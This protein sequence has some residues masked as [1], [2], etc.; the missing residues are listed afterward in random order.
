MTPLVSQFFARSL[1]FFFVVVLGFV[2]L[3]PRAADA[4]VSPSGEPGIV[5]MGFGRAAEPAASA[6]LQFLI[7]PSE[8]SY[9]GM[10]EVT[11]GEST[12]AGPM[13]SPVMEG[14]PGMP[15]SVT[16]EQLD[17]IVQALVDGGVASDAIT[18][19]VPD[20]NEMFLGPGSPETGEILAE[21]SNPEEQQLADLVDAARQ[22][23]RGANLSVFHVGAAFEASDCATLTQQARE[24]AVA[25]ARAR[26]E[27]LAQAVG[28]ALGDL[29]QA[30][31]TPYYGPES[32]GS[33]APEGTDPGTYG[34]YGPGTYPAYDPGDAAEAFVLAQVTLTFAFGS[35]TA[36][37]T[38]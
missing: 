3:S 11:V 30:A 22:A 28:T 15:P 13:A 1:P 35:D 27:G 26:A 19:N 34:P 7:S 37:P 16:A 8:M 24:A 2:A 21:V 18:V 9:M 36:T 17:P 25:D 32:G 6:S 38:S 31:E 10:S 14:V 23:A 33:C 20:T 4:Q 5:A 12:E 29:I